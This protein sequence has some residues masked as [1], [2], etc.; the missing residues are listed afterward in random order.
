[1]VR[2]NE[3]YTCVLQDG[4]WKIVDRYG[5]SIDGWTHI[6]Y[7]DARTRADDMNDDVIARRLADTIAKR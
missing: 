2:D 3:G 4:G 5:Q 7:E 1:M 6:R